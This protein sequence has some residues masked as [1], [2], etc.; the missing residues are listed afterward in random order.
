MH[1]RDQR[2][3][4][5]TNLSTCN[6]YSESIRHGSSMNRFI[7]KFVMRWDM[8]MKLFDQTSI[9][10]VWIFMKRISMRTWVLNDIKEL[11]CAINVRKIGWIFSLCI[12][13]VRNIELLCR[14]WMVWFQTKYVFLLWPQTHKTT[15]SAHS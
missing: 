8:V 2:T 15:T 11:F 5:E 9:S 14:Q 10:K 6:L 12:Y 4:S 3:N 1:Q 13:I 7:C